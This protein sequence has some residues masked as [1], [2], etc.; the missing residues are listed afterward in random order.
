MILVCLE[1]GFLLSSGLGA[2]QNGKALRRLSGNEPYP[3]LLKKTGVLKL[4]QSLFKSCGIGLCS[5][6]NKLPH[7]Q[8]KVGSQQPGVH[9]LP[10]VPMTHRARFPDDFWLQ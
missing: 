4:V 1:I 7:L 3:A 10:D 2:I 9:C 5:H 6:P 8:M